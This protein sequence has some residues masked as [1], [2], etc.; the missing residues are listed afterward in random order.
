MMWLD[1]FL[2]VFVSALAWCLAI[3]LVGALIGTVLRIRSKLGERAKARATRA[4]LARLR[5][6]Q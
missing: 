4:F 6:G 3:T 1:V 5:A 2:Q